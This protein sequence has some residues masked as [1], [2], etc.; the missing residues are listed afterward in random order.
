MQLMVLVTR[1]YYA[2]ERP[3]SVIRLSEMLE[4]PDDIVEELVRN[5]VE[6]GFLIEAGGS[7]DAF[8]PGQPPEE[9]SVSSLLQYLRNSSDEGNKG[10]RLRTDEKILAV[11]STAESHAMNPID[12]MNLK[13]LASEDSLSRIS[14]RSGRKE[15]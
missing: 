13:Q 2:G 5:L 14:Q 7:E 3:L 10:V 15:G 1:Q 11:L 6:G 4:I 9:S 8:A 12:D